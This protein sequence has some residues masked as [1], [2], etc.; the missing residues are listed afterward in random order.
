[1]I[2]LI[3][4]STIISNSSYSPISGIDNPLPVVP[5]HG[6]VIFNLRVEPDNWIKMKLGVGLWDFFMMSIAYGGENIVGRGDIT[7]GKDLW[8]DVRSYLYSDYENHILV[9]YST[10]PFSGAVIK[11]LYLCAGREQ[12]IGFG[13]IFG[14]AGINYNFNNKQADFFGD[15]YLNLGESH[16]FIIEYTAGLGYTK[17]NI[18]NF[19]YLN[20]SMSLGIQIDL[21]DII[22]GDIGRELQVIFRES[23]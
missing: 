10:E 13:R 1:M 12:G 20:Q 23:F 2:Y 19:G 15:A 7:W 14:S 18:F 8:V 21:K 11:G 17:K 22:N 5:G 4:F 16:Y 9:G 6:E 3:I